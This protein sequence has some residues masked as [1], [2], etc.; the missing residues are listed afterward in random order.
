[1]LKE[2]VDSNYPVSFRS[3]SVLQELV[4]LSISSGHKAIEVSFVSEI[5][6]NIDTRYSNRSDRVFCLKK[7]YSSLIDHT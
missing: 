3:W 1:M 6:S 2:P 7:G 4:I 5:S